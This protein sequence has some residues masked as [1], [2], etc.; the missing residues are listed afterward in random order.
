[1]ESALWHQPLDRLLDFRPSQACLNTIHLMM[2][3]MWRAPKLH[4]SHRDFDPYFAAQRQVSAGAGE[5]GCALVAQCVVKRV[6]GGT[7]DGRVAVANRV[8]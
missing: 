7:V 3:R 1:M 5:R 2:R 6:A 4:K 8:G